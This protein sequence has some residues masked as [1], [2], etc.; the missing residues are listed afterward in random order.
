MKRIGCV[1][2]VK[3]EKVEEYLRLHTDVW[4]G[5][6]KKIKQCNIEKYSIFHK[7]LP[8]GEHYLFS[9]LEYVGDDFDA[10]MAKIAE[11]EETQRWWDVCKPLLEP[12]EDLPP[13]EV[14]SEVQE[15]FHLD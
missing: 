7:K 11:D 2:R 1:V 3:P 12:V 13:G 5:V 14:W 4:P 10:D 15:V 9:Y 8:T 6:L